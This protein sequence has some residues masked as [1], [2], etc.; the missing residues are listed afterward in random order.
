MDYF[1]V[2]DNG[3][4]DYN[5][6]VQKLKETKKYSKV[7]IINDDENFTSAV[8][9]LG[10]N[11]STKQFTKKDFTFHLPKY[12]KV[13]STLE[14]ECCTICQDKFNQNEYYREL[15]ECGH[16]FHKKCID[17]WFYKSQ[18]YGCPLCRKNPFCLDKNSL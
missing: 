6:I 14:N 5:N 11:D 10:N 13:D 9:D 18:S 16:C 7:I 12:K 1:H 8:V 4:T 3:N 2:V 17:E 15:C